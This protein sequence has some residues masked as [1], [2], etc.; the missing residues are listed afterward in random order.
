MKPE[1]EV[2]REVFCEAFFARAFIDASFSCT[3]KRYALSDMLDVIEEAIATRRDHLETPWKNTEERIDKMHENDR[4]SILNRRYW[5]RQKWL[6]KHMRR[7]HN[8][9]VARNALKMVAI[10]LAS[11]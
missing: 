3:N 5:E 7:W 11:Q 1:H 10:R 4:N 2:S 9:K 8:M 6:G